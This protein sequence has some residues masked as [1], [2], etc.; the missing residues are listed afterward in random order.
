MAVSAAETAT[1]QVILEAARTRLL[2]DGYAGFSTR[3]VAHE[4]GVHASVRVSA[5][6]ERVWEHVVSPVG[7]EALLGEGARLGGKGEPWR[8]QDGS[9]GVVRSF[10]PL[11]QVRVTWHPRED[12]PLSMVD[13]QLHPD[14]D[15]TR[16][17]L[18]HEGRGSAGD[19]R[20]DLQ[21]WDDA[22]NRLAGGLQT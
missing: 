21:H 22:L 8:A 4:A 20:G 11:E 15:G 10:H 12:G 9:Y 14:G 6:A 13:L 18:F 19:P 17:E 1:S 5:P 7:T 3:K 2:A 16:V